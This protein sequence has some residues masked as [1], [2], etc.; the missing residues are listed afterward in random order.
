MVPGWPDG[1]GEILISASSIPSLSGGRIDLHSHL[2]PGIDDGCPAWTDSIACVRQLIDR[3]FVGTVCTP[4]VISDQFPR[5]V[6][7]RIAEWVSQLRERLAGEGLSYQ[8]WEGGEV[9]IAPGILGWFDK[10]GIPTLG[11]SRF[12]LTD[13]WERAW[14]EY[15]YRLFED[16]IEAGY[17]PILAHPE[18][19]CMEEQELFKLIDALK[20]LGVWLQG[21][22]NSLSGGEGEQ[23]AAWSRAW[24][25]EGAY[26]LVATDMHRPEMLAGR[27]RG[28]ETAERI[29]GTDG[30][31]NMLEQKPRLIVTQ[32]KESQ[33]DQASA[34]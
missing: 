31:K 34:A 20:E 7:E 18:R 12:V 28:I 8:L 32:A 11:P 30:L 5:N 15:G 22:F 25:S 14:P 19:M 23:A 10:I 3:G 24:L 9:R 29:L 21:N 33:E 2:L 16:L 26:D 17:Q 4:H 13:W 6:P 27:F 1:N